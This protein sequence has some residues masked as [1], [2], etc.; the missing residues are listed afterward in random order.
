MNGFQ[1]V[2]PAR[3]AK[4]VVL[5]ATA[6]TALVLAAGAAASTASLTA[7]NYSPLAGGGFVVTLTGGGFAHNDEVALEWTDADGNHLVAL[8]PTGSNGG[9]TNFA[10]LVQGNLPVTYNASDTHGNTASLTVTA[11]VGVPSLKKEECRG[12]YEALGFRN[13]G[14]CTAFVQSHASSY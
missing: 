3:L 1:S 11:S 14:Q 7:T 10:T 8:I 5:L 6:A 2:K 12:G 4:Y 9:F 13:E